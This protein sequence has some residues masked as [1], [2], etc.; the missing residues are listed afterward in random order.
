MHVP[1]GAF[2]L[3]IKN[4][5]LNLYNTFNVRVPEALI[6]IRISATLTIFQLYRGG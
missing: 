5:N 3:L 4:L 2:F 1:Y 6:C